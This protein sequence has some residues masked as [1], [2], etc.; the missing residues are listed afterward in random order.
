M[1][2]LNKSEAVRQRLH[3]FLQRLIAFANHELP[4][5]DHLESK[6]SV[7][8]I[9]RDTKAP[10]LI[11]KSEIRFLAALVS[12]PPGTAP[13]TKAKTH[14]KQDL[15]T[16]KDFLGRLEDNRD[17]TQGTGLWHFTLKLWHRSIDRNLVGFDDLWQQRKAQTK[18]Q[19]KAQTK[20]QTKAQ[21][22]NQAVPTTQASHTSISVSTQPNERKTPSHN[23]PARDYSTFIGRARS[24]QQLLSFLTKS[25]PVA[26]ISLVGIGGIGK[27][28]LALEAAHQCINTKQSTQPETSNTR[29][30]T[31]YF[32]AIIF[33]CAKTQQFTPQGILP[34][35]RYSRTLQDL[36]RAI[37]K[38]LNCS[39]LLKGDFENQRENIYE[40]LSQQRSLLILDNLESLSNQNQQA[41]L[42]FL[43]ELPATVKAIVTSRVHLTMDAVI[44]IEGLT[45]AEGQQ[46]IQHQAALKSI[47]LDPPVC[48]TLYHHTGGTPAAMVYAL[49]Q[50]AAGYPLPTVL[51]QLAQHTSDYSQYYLKNTVSALADTPAQQLLIALSLFPASATREAL[52]DI[53]QLTEASTVESFAKLKQLSLIV[54]TNSRYT[55]LPLARD[56]LM[57]QQQTHTALRERWLGWHE[58]WLAPH[59]HPNWREWHD[60]TLIDQEWENIQAAVDWCIVAK[61][62]NAFRRLWPGLKGYTQLRGYWNERLSWLKWWIDCLQ[63]HRTEAAPS[64]NNT[65]GILEA[66]WDLGW[67]LSV[68]GQPK[69]LTEAIHY[70]DQVWQQQQQIPTDMQLELAIDQAVVYLF[71]D[72]LSQAAHWIKTAR[73]FINSDL[74]ESK[75]LRLDYYT[76]QLHYRK[77]NYEK[78]KSLYK[79]ILKAVRSE[80]IERTLIESKNPDLQKQ[81][82]EVYS[83]NWLV[84]IALKENDLETATMLLEQ[85]WPIIE[86]R[87]D[88]RSQAFHE[89]SQAQ[90]AKQRQNLPAFKHWSQQAISTFRSLGMKAQVKEIETWLKDDS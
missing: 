67:T 36:F 63:H 71:K 58:Q 87:Q 65:H 83:L 33:I 50:V 29:A 44:P 40:L 47:A 26:R 16:L 75:Q 35:Y 51:P 34:S 4:E 25:S 43:Y 30:T 31:P 21:P 22:E 49:G 90:L 27:T 17:R 18:L 68:L 55:M 5:C 19:T 28:A 82:F 77:D 7:R 20:L 80:Q 10:K 59:Q 14:L 61:R 41:I 54:E 37:T 73:A 60:Y 1:P 12:T 13:S 8:W 62:E 46:F 39:E 72:D 11:V 79:K 48:Q 45:P 2:Q 56:Y 70:Y 32:D 42:S 81:Q 84:D 64:E 24:L 85:S 86:Q 52:I 9:D 89:R 38:T 78:A 15:R 74:P 69:Q 88:V 6:I 57:T 66:Q 53:A 23:L 76:A 3:I